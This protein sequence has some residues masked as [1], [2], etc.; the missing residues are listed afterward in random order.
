MSTIGA[1]VVNTMFSQV[2]L[3]L[4]AGP[5]P[6]TSAP[7]KVYV[8]WTSGALSRIHYENFMPPG[9]SIFNILLSNTLIP[10]QPPIING[11][12]TVNVTPDELLTWINRGATLGILTSS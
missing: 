3:L 2:A 7:R 1:G 12:S 11:A 5:D 9:E 8:V 10:Q 4:D 6:E